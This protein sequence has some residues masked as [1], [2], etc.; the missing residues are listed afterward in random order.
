MLSLIERYGY[1]I[2][3]LGVTLEGVGI[4]LPGET[5]LI[6]AGALAHRGSLTLWETMVMGS[7]GAVMG[8]QAGYC[9][10]RFGGRPFVLRWGR[11]TFI[12]PE[13]LGRAETFFEQHGGKA[14]FFAR[15]ITGLRVFGALV[16]GMSHMAWGKFAL[17]NVLGGAV[18]ATADRKSTR[19]NSSHANISYAVFCLKK[20]KKKMQALLTIDNLYASH[21]RT[22]HTVEYGR[23]QLDMEERDYI[24]LNSCY[25]LYLAPLLV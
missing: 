6:A 10:G 4:P 2:V 5:V 16:A 23:V 13:R 9:V 11:H 21:P 7:L 1:L 25:D 14:V 15:F 18:W 3:F 8:G 12:T 19:L 24:Q 20:K 17:Y 22:V